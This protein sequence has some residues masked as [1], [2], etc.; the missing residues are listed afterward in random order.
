ME[1]TTKTV[2]FAELSP[3]HQEAVSK[4]VGYDGSSYNLKDGTK[5]TI[6]AEGYEVVSPSSEVIIPGVLEAVADGIVPAPENDL[7]K[8]QPFTGGPSDVPA[9]PPVDNAHVAEGAEQFK[10]GDSAVAPEGTQTGGTFLNGVAGGET[11]VAPEQSEANTQEGTA[12][13]STE[14]GEANTQA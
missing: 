7:A 14:S 2:S 12:S 13:T 10:T 6:V 5:I 8:K 4:A 1:S 9:Q 11:T 3:L